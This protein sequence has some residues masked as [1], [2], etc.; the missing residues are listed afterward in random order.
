MSSLASN[1]SQMTVSVAGSE[2]PLEPYLDDVFNR[3]QQSLNNTHCSVRELVQLIE[4]GDLF[5]ELVESQF[6]IV[7]YIDD[8]AG[9]FKELKKVLPQIRGK[10]SNDD[11]KKILEAAKLR[12]KN[13]K[14]DTQ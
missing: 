12:F 11:E 1:L 3:L 9:L 10:P 8:M 4:R 6:A 2:V 13:R 14:P 5:K 7:E